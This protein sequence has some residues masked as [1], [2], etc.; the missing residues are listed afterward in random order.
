MAIFTVTN[1]NDAGEGSLRQAVLN[2]NGS[3]N[4][5]TIVFAAE[6][7]GQTIALTSGELV[8]SNDVTIDGDVNGDDKADITISGSDND[9][10]FKVFDQN[11]PSTDVDLKSL[12]LTNGSARGYSFNQ[13]DDGGAIYMRGKSLDIVDCTIKDSAANYGGGG[14]DIQTGAVRIVNSLFTGNSAGSY[15]GAIRN[16][17]GDSLSLTNSTL[18]GNTSAGAGGIL[19]LSYGTLRLDSS[20][21][22]NNTGGSGITTGYGTTTINNSVVA[23]NGLGGAAANNDI[24]GTVTTANH[25]FFGTTETITTNIGSINGG[26]NPLLGT[27]T[28]NG[29]T[30]LTHAPLGGSALIDA[31]NNAVLPKDP[32]DIDGDA[33]KTET[34]PEDGRG[35][36]RVINGTTDIGAVEF[37]LQVSTA[38]D[39]AFGGGTLAAESADGGGL[40]LREALAFANANAN[41]DHI[42]FAANLAGQTLV[43]TRGQLSITQDVTIDGDTNGDNKADITISGNNASGI[44][45]V[46]AGNTDLLSLTL[47]NGRSERGGA[48]DVTGGSLDLVNSTLSG[49]SATF[50]GGAL[51]F[52]NATV[53]I[54]NSLIT[55]NTSD[56]SA[57]RHLRFWQQRLRA[58]QQHTAR[59]LSL[60]VRWGDLSFQCDRHGIVQHHHRKRGRRLDRFHDTWRRL[61]HFKLVYWN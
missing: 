38:N 46:T 51:A 26:G 45:A 4:A 22:V 61:L 7:A 21:V 54:A 35:E 59:Q 36:T 28:D 43:L 48:I 37:Q 33:N 24:G 25:S 57:G 13:D 55:G 34:L 9:R 16:F 23:G 19:D 30:V 53:Q 32:F 41:A 3:S 17:S 40:S 29:G 11:T 47:V 20:T 52:S 60:R 50:R 5:D 42:T 49:N 27:L 58:H 18:S 56:S 2:A 15:G 44:F 10:I 39:E 12:T 8:L 1:T 14:L 6:L 31:G